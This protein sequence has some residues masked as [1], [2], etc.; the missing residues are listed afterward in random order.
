MQ[1][2]SKYTDVLFL[3]TVSAHS[4]FFKKFSTLRRT[5]S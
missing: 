2:E 1:D 3:L 4:G 5:R